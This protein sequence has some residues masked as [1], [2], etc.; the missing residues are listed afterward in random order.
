MS[1]KI[2]FSPEAD[3][4]ISKW[5]KSNPLPYKK[6]VSYM[7]ELAEHPRT[8][9]GHPKP[10]ISGNDVTYSRR[11]SANDRLIYDIYDEKVVV[12]ILSVEGHYN[13]K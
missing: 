9:T 11:L 1:Y 13:D 4:I 2:E 5:K 7:P 10:L 12:L 8:G 3:K 6:L